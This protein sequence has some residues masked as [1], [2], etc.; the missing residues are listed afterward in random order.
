MP[1]LSPFK[2]YIEDLFEAYDASGPMDDLST[3]MYDN[4]LVRTDIL[5]KDGNDIDISWRK[6]CIDGK[7]DTKEKK[8]KK[9][10]RS[11]IDNQIREF[12]EKYNDN[13][14]KLCREEIKEIHVDHEIYFDTLVVDFLEYVRNKGITIPTEFEDKDDRT[15]RP[16]FLQCDIYFESEWLKYHYRNAKLRILCQDCNLKRSKPKRK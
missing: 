12:K 6:G 10:M 1:C 14:C 9:A 8:L 13:I 5:K 7:S 4:L 11:S 3:F 15:N 16:C 2:K